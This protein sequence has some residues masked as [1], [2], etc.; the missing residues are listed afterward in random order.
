MSYSSKDYPL[1]R[2]YVCEGSHA[3]R[4]V[5]AVTAFWN[6]TPV[7]RL[8]CSVTVEICADPCCAQMFAVCQH[9]RMSWDETQQV[10]TCDFCG[11]DGT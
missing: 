7:L 6:H 2:R 3:S 1:P 4:T 8:L 9:D 5:R 11:K 10:L